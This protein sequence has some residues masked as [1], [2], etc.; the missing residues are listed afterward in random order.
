[1]LSI[2]SVVAG[3]CRSPL[4]R[5]SRQS[6]AVTTDCDHVTMVQQSMDALINPQPV[7]DRLRDT[8][9]RYRRA[10]GV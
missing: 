9:Q 5:F 8:V 3:F 4:R 1:M 7:N 2:P 6:V 10:T